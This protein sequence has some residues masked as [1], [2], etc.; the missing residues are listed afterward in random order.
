MHRVIGFLVLTAAIHAGSAAAQDL[1]RIGF[2]SALTY[3]AF[4]SRI[5]AFR[6]GLIELGYVEGKNI[7]VEYRWAEGRG[8]R[9]PALAAELESRQVALIVSAGPAATRPALQ[10]TKRTPIVM[11]FDSDPV[12]SGFIDSLARPGGRITGLSY[13]APEVS[14][15]QLDILKQLIPQIAQVAILGDS[16]EPGNAH[17]LEQTKRAATA[18]RMHI[19]HFDSRAWR[20]M[21]EVLMA[22]RKAGSHAVVALSS[23]LFTGQSLSDA[24]DQA[25]RER[26][27]VIYWF[28]H[29]VDRG[30]LISYS[31]NMDDLFR[32]SAVYVHKILKGTRPSELPVE[33][34]SK[35][36]LVVN[37]RAA[38]EIGLTIPNE[39]LMRADRVITSAPQ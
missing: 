39:I 9:L 26:L 18:L 8:E 21:R 29:P 14:A 38:K 24:L 19:Q 36:D 10:A 30:G 11:A 6:R 16:Q 25:S 3:E 23:P 5:D 33:Q 7:I 34:P 17:A 27:P 13:V 35:F 2:L 31:A 15:K 1:P 37:L 20:N 4:P 12:G 32:R 22:I 28:S